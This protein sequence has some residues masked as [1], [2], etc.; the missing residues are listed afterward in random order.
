MRFAVESDFSKWLEVFRPLYGRAATAELHSAQREF[1]RTAVAAP[2]TNG[3]RYQRLVSRD[4]RHGLGEFFTPAWLADLV[5]DRLGYTGAGTLVDPS[6]GFGVFVQCALDR[7]A[8][9]AGVAGYEI[10]PLIAA[11]AQAGGLPVE[12]RD[13]LCHPGERRFDFVAGNPPWVN[14]RYL[15]ASYRERISPLWERYGLLPQGGLR[16]RLGA[17][18]DDLSIL[19]TYLCAD[20]LLAP[21]GRMGLL[22]SRSLL[23]SAGGGRA[24]RRFK[25][26]DG[27]CL[28]VTGV[29]EIAG[30]CPFP[31]ATNQTVAV[32]FQ[33]SHEPAVYPVPYF[34]EGERWDA[35]PVTSDRASPWAITRAGSEREFAGLRGPSRYAARVGVHTGGATGVYWVDILDRTV[36]SVTIQNR[37]GA[38]RRKWP[39]S[40]A[41]VEPDLVRTLVRG[42]DVARWSVQP[43]CHI[44]LPHMSGGK[45]VPE[46]VMGERWPR[47]FAYFEQFRERM[48]ERPHYRAHFEHARLPYWSMYNVGPYTFAPYRVVWREQS[49]AFQCAVIENA[50][51]IADAKLVVLACASG[52]EAHYLAA[53]LNSGPANQ[54]LSSFLIRV[55]ISTHVL[56]HLRVADFDARD[57]RHL[58]LAALSRACHAGCDVEAAA[59]RMDALG[60]EVWAMDRAY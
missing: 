2:E 37:A 55:Q 32:M 35:Q 7:G 48:L 53:L 27:R 52:E 4:A 54:Y 17:G 38:G 3:Q 30:S 24:F 16:A 42:R 41:T 40:T 50:A 15:D 26:P 36:D 21:A 25:L 59:R 60:R 47:T 19:F 43:S 29:H 8:R 22:L 46:S 23:Q 39:E 18:M 10:N 9:P 44:V 58:E 12:E 31:R 1:A 45:P 56:R 20:R 6:A 33:L 57:G 51:L 34:R 13:S 49:T 11:Y 28:Q 14:W 5:L